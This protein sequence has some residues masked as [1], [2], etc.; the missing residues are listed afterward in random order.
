M[1]AQMEEYIILNLCRVNVQME[2]YGIIVDVFLLKFHVI[3]VEY[4]IQLYMPANALKEPSQI[5]I[6]VI[7]SRFVEME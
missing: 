1:P 3:M 2:K 4:G 7:L 6:S 5:I